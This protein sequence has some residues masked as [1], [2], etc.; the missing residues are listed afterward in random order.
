MIESSI[1][2]NGIVEFGLN[3][4][5]ALIAM[6]RKLVVV[7]KF[8]GKRSYKVSVHGIEELESNVMQKPGVDLIQYPSYLCTNV[9]TSSQTQEVP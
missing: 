7:E 3:F 4:L 1:K 6:L 9:Y 5:I 2:E 8:F